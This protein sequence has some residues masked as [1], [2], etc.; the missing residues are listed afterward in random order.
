MYRIVLEVHKMLLVCVD[1]FCIRMQRR[2]EKLFFQC[3]NCK[4]IIERREQ[5]RY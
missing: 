1:I 4:K 5:P 3:L 2:N